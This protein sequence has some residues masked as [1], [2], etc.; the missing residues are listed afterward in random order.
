MNGV[1]AKNFS[2]DGFTIENNVDAVKKVPDKVK[3]DRVTADYNRR[4]GLSIIAGTNITITNST[5]K[6]TEGTPSSDGI[7]LERDKPYT[8]LLENMV[9]RHKRM[10]NNGGYGLIFAFSHH[11]RVEYNIIPSNKEGGFFKQCLRSYIVRK[12]NQL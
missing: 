12:Q 6:H 5:F 1:T 3:L 4:Q 7:A 8:L 2:G 11:S 9:I 10:Q